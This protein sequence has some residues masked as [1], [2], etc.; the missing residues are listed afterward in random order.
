M[1]MLPAHALPLHIAYFPEVNIS[2]QGK[3]VATIHWSGV[4]WGTSYKGVVREMLPRVSRTEES[5][6]R[7]KDLFKF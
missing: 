2:F 7:F 4:R 5:K 3:K 6:E 1:L